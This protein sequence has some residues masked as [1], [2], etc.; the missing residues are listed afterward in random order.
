MVAALVDRHQ[1]GDEELTAEP[2]IWVCLALRA[3][4]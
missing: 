2:E 4:L 3:A 1:Y